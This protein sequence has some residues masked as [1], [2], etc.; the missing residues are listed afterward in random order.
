MAPI[1]RRNLV[2][3]II[4]EEKPVTQRIVETVI[5]EEPKPL[6]NFSNPLEFILMR[7]EYVKK[8]PPLKK[9]FVKQRDVESDSEGEMS[10]ESVMKSLKKIVKAINPKRDFARDKQEEEKKVWVQVGSQ[11]LDL[12]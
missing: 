7:E 8:N 3:T 10:M 4:P 5:K 12:L 1:R 6:S 9:T 2:R 11:F